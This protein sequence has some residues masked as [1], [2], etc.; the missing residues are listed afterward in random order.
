MSEI[1][2]LRQICKNFTVLY[3]ED[4]DRLRSRVW[5]YLSKFFKSVAV[6]KDGKEG[7][8]VYRQDRYDIVI[9]DI[10]MPNLDG[11]D[12]SAAI[13]D[14][15][16][17][18][19]III[20]SAYSDSENFLKSIKI[21]I[22]GYILKPF[23]YQQINEVIYKVTKALKESKENEI[24]KNRLLEL[25]HD[26]IEE[27]RGLEKEREKNY[28]D[29]LYTLVDLIEQRDAYTGGHSNRVAQYCKLIAEE[30][31]MDKKD[32]DDI[33]EA[34]I[35]HD[36]GKIAIP[37]SVLLKPGKLNDIEYRL[38]KKHVEIGYNVLAK[39][40]MFKDV[41]RIIKEHHERIDGSGYPNGLR[42]DEISLCGMIMAVADS[43]DAMTTNRIYQAKKSPAEALAEIKS[44]SGVR[45]DSRVVDAAFAALKD[46]EIEQNINQLPTD[47]MEKERFSYFYKDQLTQAY[48]KNY[49]DLVLSQRN[50][51]KMHQVLNILFL[52]NFNT[53]NK[54]HGWIGGDIFLK[55]IVD[56]LIQNYQN[57]LIFRIQGDDFVVLSKERIN[58]EDI[59][60][61]CETNSISCSH[62]QINL[63][64]TDIISTKSL[65]IYIK[66]S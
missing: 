28:K 3:V 49:L 59:Y 62:M 24:F 10:S 60:G 25:V 19:K 52:K 29:T 42:G 55:N 66:N 31:E 57:D 4:E 32:I 17:H 48:N 40:P 18:Q 65:E 23:E 11:L 38:I 2:A 16:K 6:A 33:Y 36:I 41:A 56:I 51:V 26:K 54:K 45:F 50:F 58:F 35:L 14:I 46:V 27:I 5:A 61:L 15:D 1:E 64:E 43:F 39:S 13:K 34:G 30:L 22:D 9:T 37:D 47:E 63:Q 53:Y 7:L 12:M 21:G 44:L 20:V 8:E